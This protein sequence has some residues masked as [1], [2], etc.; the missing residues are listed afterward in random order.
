[1]QL[2]SF[3]Y[4][5]AITEN[6]TLSAA[7]DSVFISQPALSQ[8]IRKIEEEVGAALFRR[9]GHSMELTPAG[10]VFLQCARR[11]LQS[12][13]A[14]KREVRVLDQ[15]AQDT[16]RMGISPFYSQHYLPMMLPRFLA[17]YPEFKVDILEDI[18][19]NLEKKL[20]A[21][22]LDFCALPLYPKNDLLEY[23]TIYQENILLAIPRKHPLNAHYPADAQSGVGFPHIDL[24][25]LKNEAFIGLKKI[26]KFSHIGLRLCEEA[27]FVPNTIC[28]TLN[29]ETVH[30]MVASGLGVGF[31][32]EILTETITDPDIRPCYYQVSSNVYR[33]YAI[34]QR[35]G[36]VLSRPAVLLTS[37]LREFFR[38][39]QQN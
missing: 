32:P 5:I 33:A 10:E 26:Q 6:A 19:V 13:E 1:M 38:N 14:M 27:G 23:E 20:L 36:T 37:I 31:I 4:F 24:S 34:A 35:P 25:L 12:Y 2:K 11:I 15:A 17:Q 3:Q 28:E 39:R 16:V 7:A 22:D 8:Q 18:S 29:W 30:M 21:G 9:E